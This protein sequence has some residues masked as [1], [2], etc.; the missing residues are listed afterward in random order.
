MLAL[1]PKDYLC[2]LLVLHDFGPPGF[3]PRLPV[4]IYQMETLM[5]TSQEKQDD[6]TKLNAIMF[7][8]V[9]VRNKCP[10]NVC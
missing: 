4:F 5:P 8:K 7:M 3:F 1:R 6:E 9:L 2:Y 10:Q